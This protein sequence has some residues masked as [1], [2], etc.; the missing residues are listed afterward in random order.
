MS[1]NPFNWPKAINILEEA[2]TPS[3]GDM[4]DPQVQFGAFKAKLD[5]FVE[6]LNALDEAD[7]DNLKKQANEL[8]E[9]YRIGD[10][11]SDEALLNDE[12]SNLS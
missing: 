4:S 3:R 8:F 5:D 7:R 12:A 11:L 2:S 9:D 10:C 1:N 6:V